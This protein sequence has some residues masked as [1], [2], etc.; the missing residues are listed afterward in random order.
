MV[1]NFARP[2][3]EDL[4]LA[5]PL[6]VKQLRR[7]R[8]G[9]QHGI[10]TGCRWISIPSRIIRSFAHSYILNF[11]LNNMQGKPFAAANDSHAGRS[12]IRHFHSYGFG[13][14]TGGVTKEGDHAVFDA[15]V[16]GPGSHDGTVID[17]IDN[18]FVNPRGLESVLFL[19]VA[20]DL[21]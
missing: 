10:Y 16:F 17:A 9:F 2:T 14:L 20:R 19:K 7:R 1:P 5:N 4:I 8:G 11:T 15:L 21:N 3:F 6:S 18:D 12:R 13:E